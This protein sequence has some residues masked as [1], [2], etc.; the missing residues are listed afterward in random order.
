MDSIFHGNLWVG[1]KT[2][3]IFVFF[4]VPGPIEH[5]FSQK[6]KKIVFKVLPLKGVVMVKRLKYDFA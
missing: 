3:D 4:L 1:V 2:D 6:K 5:N